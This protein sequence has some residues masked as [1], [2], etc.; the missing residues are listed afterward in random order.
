MKNIFTIMHRELMR[1]FKSPTMMFA[2][3][4]PGIVLFIVYSLMG[5]M[6]HE[7]NDKA[8]MREYTVY[9]VNLDSMP[10]EIPTI[11]AAPVTEGGLEHK[12]AF[13]AITAGDLDAKK[14]L[15][16]T[17]GVDLVLVFD[18]DFMEAIESGA[19]PLPEVQIFYNPSDS[20]SYYAFNSVLWPALYMFQETLAPTPF[21]SPIIQVLDEDKAIAG[22]I[23]MIIPMM[24]LM[25]LALGCVTV[26][27]ESI[28]GEKERGTM[29]T[30]L[31][32]PT[33]RGHIAIGK[34]A[35]LSI[36]AIISA[37]GAFVG[38]LASLP[39]LLGES[40]L[41]GRS[42]F[43]MYGFTNIALLLCVMVVTVLFI[44]SIMAAASTFA[45][46]IKEATAIVTPL[47]FVFGVIGMLTAMV[48]I[49]TA[50]WHYLIPVYNAASCIVAIISLEAVLLNIII[51]IVSNLV[52]V[53]VLVWL[54]TRLF[55]NEKIMFA[56]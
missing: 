5:G 35:S 10:A 53:V 1:F 23:A 51:T 38:V 17:G 54:L 2:L 12:F 25:F 47:M 33:K 30:L 11:I 6:M 36:L 14:E 29:A 7:D 9:V 3:L 31:V 49:P 34:I 15:L 8:K 16:K 42:P 24:L 41:D 27:P 26:T 45:K 46:N 19:I 20:N 48:G 4:S 50:F 28:A 43:A 39:K 37:V 44:V 21:A 40:L 22:F 13:K 52:F 32:T 55:N 56:K 18:V